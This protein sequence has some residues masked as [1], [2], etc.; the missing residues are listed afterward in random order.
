MRLKP[1]ASIVMRTMLVFSSLPLSALAQEKEEGD[2]QNGKYDT[3]YEATYGN[4]TLN[5]TVKDV[6]GLKTCHIDKPGIM[7]DHG[8]YMDVRKFTNL[9]EM[10]Q[11]GEN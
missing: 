3:G 4:L 1:I 9:S 8:D 2:S 7:T 10:E 5:E 11:D 6:Y